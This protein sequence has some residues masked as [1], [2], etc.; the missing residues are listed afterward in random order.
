MKVVIFSKIDGRLAT[1]QVFSSR[2]RALAWLASYQRRP[3]EHR[4]FKL[5]P[6]AKE[7]K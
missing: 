6:T 2:A 5:K 4:I 1:K 3:A 7:V